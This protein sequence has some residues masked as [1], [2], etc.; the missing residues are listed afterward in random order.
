MVKSYKFGVLF[1]KE[2]QT[3]EEEMFS[4][5]H[6]D[7]ALE[8]FLTFLGQKVQLK[9]WEGYRGGLDARNDSTGTHSIYTTYSDFEIMFHVSTYLP[10]T[11]E[12]PQQLERKRHLGND[13]VVLVFKEGNTP[14]V[15]NT[16][17]S[18]F[19]RMS[20]PR[21][22]F[23]FLIFFNACLLQMYLLSFNRSR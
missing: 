22:E 5:V 10:Y 23:Q 3:R 9:G 19:N 6:G 12:N 13:I 20:N 7:E 15:P 2:G 16:V 17:I 11:P 1:C 4:N 18:E 14:Y 21:S 8:S